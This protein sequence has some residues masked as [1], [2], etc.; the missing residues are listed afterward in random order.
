M[1]SSKKPSLPF[2]VSTLSPD[3]PSI[4]YLRQKALAEYEAELI[5]ENLKNNQFQ[6]SFSS[7]T[8]NVT[9][10]YS[11]NTR[12]FTI[13]NQVI[14]L[15][16]KRRLLIE[17]LLKNKKIKQVTVGDYSEKLYGKG[18]FQNNPK[19]IINRFTNLGNS[20]SSMISEKYHIENFLEVH[21]DIVFI[22]PQYQYIP[23]Q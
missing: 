20:F 7:K 14:K 18:I 19:V 1:K 13:N 23:Q 12:R 21:N 22:N 6:Q 11:Y 3:S 16:N 2:I 4:Q 10:S 8:D 15:T 17:L 5:S 9:Y